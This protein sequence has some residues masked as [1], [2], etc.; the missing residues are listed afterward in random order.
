[1]RARTFHK[2]LTIVTLTIALSLSLPAFSPA[3]H[4]QASHLKIWVVSD[5]DKILRDAAPLTSS[6]VWS[7]ASGRVGL[8]A[9][10]NE[11]VAFQAMI[12]ADGAGLHGVDV[13]MGALSGPGGTIPAGGIELMRE[14]YL[15]VTEPSTAMYGEQSTSGP[16]AYP[17]PLVPLDAPDGGTPA[18][19]PPVSTRESGW[20]STCRRIP[21]PVST[22]EPCI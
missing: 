16:G 18:R 14:H 12:T 2:W 20:T 10:R 22:R 15:D 11:Y 17:D 5:G 19:W 6:A 13:S 4:A 9:A 7:Q 21:P 1:M 3:V 8:R